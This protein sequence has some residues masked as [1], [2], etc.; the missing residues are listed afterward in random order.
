MLLPGSKIK[1]I[2]SISL[3][4]LL[5]RLFSSYGQDLEPRAYSN[6]PVGLN[7]ALAGYAYSTG[8]VA[9]DPAVPL[10]NANFKI[11][12][13]VFGYA[14]SMKIWRMSGKIDMV[15][16]YAWLSGTADLQGQPVSREVSGLGDPRFRISLNFIGS[17]ALPLSGFKDY[18]QKLIIGASLQIRVPLSQ[19]DPERLVNIGTNRFTIKPELGLSRTV[20]RLY[21]ELSGGVAFYTVNKEFY[22]GKTRS[23]EPIGSAQGHVIY[24]F[25]RGIWTS[26]DG[27]YYWGGSTT[28]DGVKGDDLQQNTRLGL[29]VALPVNLHNSLKLYLSAG[30]LTRTGTDFNVTGLAWQYR[31]GK[32]FTGGH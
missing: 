1:L 7:F 23:Q 4:I 8:G 29:T 31:W 2:L 13:S 14:R 9:F 15:L 24:T 21:L 18:K 12:G 11:H 17:P 28:V 27:T 19:Y 16:P 30:V 10:D 32:E 6:I 25:K 26:L 5:S 22:Q 20:G 3:L